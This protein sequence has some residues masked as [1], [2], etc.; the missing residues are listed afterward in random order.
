MN[1]LSHPFLQA[2]KTNQF[3]SIY[4]LIRTE[5]P[6]Y[7]WDEFEESV[8]MSTYLLAFVVSDFESMSDGNFSVWT[9]PGALD[10]A[11]YALT[12]GPK[13]LSFFENYFDIKYPLPKLDMIAL[14]DFSAGGK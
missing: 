13:I 12:V 6:S 11:K 1:A 3:E 9:R 5:M 4:S 10:S 7:F 14:P 8:P 2:N